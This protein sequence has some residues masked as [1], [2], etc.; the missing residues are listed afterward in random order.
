MAALVMLPSQDR[1]PR[2][3]SHGPIES[4]RHGMGRRLL[5]AILIASD[6]SSTQLLIRKQHAASGHATEK[7]ERYPEDVSHFIV[8]ALESSYRIA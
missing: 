4:A 1:K 5:M 7:S 2:V 8:K 3:D 6:R